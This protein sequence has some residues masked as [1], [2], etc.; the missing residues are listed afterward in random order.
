MNPSVLPLG[1]LKRKTH[2]F[3]QSLSQSNTRAR[4]GKTH[5]TIEINALLQEATKGFTKEQ[6]R[7][8]LSPL[9]TAP[10]LYCLM[11]CDCCRGVYVALSL[12]SWLTRGLMLLHSGSKVLS[13]KA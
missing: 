1:M 5:G 4:K 13:R 10:T 9:F 2:C 11:V 7:C 6:D 8:F 3:L 12:A